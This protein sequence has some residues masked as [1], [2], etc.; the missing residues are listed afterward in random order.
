MAYE[1]ERPIGDDGAAV[2]LE[3]GLPFGHGKIVNPEVFREETQ[4]RDQVLGA[5]D[6]LLHRRGRW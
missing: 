6:D 4:G 3:K 5:W 2:I 1:N